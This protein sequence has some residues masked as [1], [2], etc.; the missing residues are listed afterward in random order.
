MLT[1]NGREVDVS[2]TVESMNSAAAA[3]LGADV[4]ADAYIDHAEWVDTGE[5]FTITEYEEH[6]DILNSLDAGDIYYHQVV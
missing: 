2:A 1:I 3:A 5:E 4:F 6:E